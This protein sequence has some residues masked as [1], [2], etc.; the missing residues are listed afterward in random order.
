[1]EA[2][3]LTDYVHRAR[4]AGVRAQAAFLALTERERE[5]L[6]LV[7]QGYTNQEIAD[8][9]I[10][11]VKTVETHR[12]HIMSKLGLQTRAELVRCALREGYLTP[13]AAA[14]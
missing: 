5:I 9:L 3:L 12:A 4:R 1:M 13:E 6:G 2:R 7:A 11:S 8:R 14:D 10:V